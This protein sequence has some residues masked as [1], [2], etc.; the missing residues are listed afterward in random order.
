MSTLRTPLRAPL[1]SRADRILSLLLRAALVVAIG[2]L[3]GGSVEADTFTCS[4]PLPPNVISENP[5]FPTENVITV[6]VSEAI[7][8]VNI[9][10]GVTHDYIDDVTIQ[11]ASPNGTTVTLHDQTGSAN[12]IQITFDDQAVANGSIPFDSLCAM[13][14]SGPGTLADFNGGNTLGDWTIS[15]LD[16]YLGGATG[17]LDTWCLIT[18]DQTVNQPALPVENLLCTSVGGSGVVDLTWS[19]PQAYTS[20][21]ISENGQPIATLPGTDTTWSSAPQSIGV[22]VTYEVTGVIGSNLPCS[23]ES[24]TIPVQ[25]NP[26]DFEV[27]A[28]PGSA[29]SNT[30]PPTVETILVNTD[31][32]LAD[33]QVQLDVSHPFIGDLTVDLAHGPVTVRLHDE[34]GG[35]LERLELTLWDL[36]VPNNSVPHNCGCLMAPS[37]PGTLSDF[38]GM[39]SLG[40]WTLTVADVYNPNFPNFGAV[41]SWCIRGYESGTVSNLACD[42]ASGVPTADITWVNPQ[43]YDSIVVYVD[44]V[45]SAVLPGTATSF[46]TPAQPIP[47]DV[48]ICI[49]PVVAGAPLNQACCTAS[50]FVTPP[51]IDDCTS[52]SG[53]GIVDV[54]WTNPVP[55]DSIQVLVGGTLLA[56]LPGTDTSFTTPALAGLPGTAE[57]CLI[58][59]Q[60][61]NPSDAACC[62]VPLL[63][64]ADVEVCRVPTTPVPVNQSVSPISD[65]MLVPSNLLIG[66][67]EVLVDIQHT[68]VGDLRIDLSGPNGA[69]VRLHDEAGGAADDLVVVYDDQGGPNIDPYDCGCP[70]VPA[71]PGTLGDYVNSP[72]L[73]AWALSIVDTFPN[74]IGFLD[75]WCIRVNAGC[76]VPPPTGV[77]CSTNGVDA[78]LSWTNTSTYSSIEVERNGVVIASLPPTATSYVDVAPPP[79][80]ARYRI[81]GFDTAQGCGNAGAAAECGIGIT[82]LIFAGDVGGANDSPQAIFDELVI[83]GRSPMIVDSFDAA[84]LASVGPFDVAWICLG[85]YPNE[86]ELSGAEAQLLA[87]LHTGDIGLDGTIDASP[88]AV[89]LESAD[90]WAYDPPTVF[91]SYDGVENFSFGNLANGNDTLADLVGADTGLGLN[92]AG[93][94]ALYQQDS[95]GNDYNDRLVPCSANPDL[96]GNQAAV[97]WRGDEFGN[98]YDIGVFYASTIAPVLT[99]TWEFGGYTGDRALLIENYILALDGGGPPPSGTFVRA[100][101]NDDG[102]VNIA[103]AVFLLNSLFVPGFGSIPCEQAADVNDDGGVNIADA[104]FTLNSLFVPGFGDVPLPN[105]AS[106]CGPDPTPTTL[107]CDVNNTCP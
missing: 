45:Q 25:G 17:V 100:D 12:T 58:G 20:I 98:P 73:G 67:V 92:L 3:P 54:T 87:E 66:E 56:T 27:C 18:S 32:V 104:V 47:G 71:G 2:L 74:N 1:H 44:G 84:A 48:A 55:Y 36:G 49:E 22:V 97:T 101:V 63:T 86:H 103:D 83:A 90:H 89:Y 43:V 88:K 102:S 19:N 14:P 80:V 13:Q 78:T 51:D 30:L 29:L 7:V 35:P 64:T 105:S 79:G 106:G 76:Q 59:L 11:V 21:E 10:V 52:A 99:Q 69:I 72:A 5:A 23:A 46:T 62:N 37:G 96:G 38:F 16:N 8:D 53:T 57:I 61:A 4:T 70:M 40:A 26:A 24:C 82:D 28:T 15:L 42:T 94:T 60:A 77:S 39:S 65:V 9:S 91:E 93:L 34:Q 95:T 6:P 81:L 33:L 41:D 107:P 31:I 50:F 68:F 75:K 85:T